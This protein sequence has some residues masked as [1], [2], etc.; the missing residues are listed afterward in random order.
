[1]S[2]GGFYRKA[3]LFTVLSFVMLAGLYAGLRA[4]GDRVEMIALLFIL[5]AVMTLPH[6]LIVERLYQE[7]EQRRNAPA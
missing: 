2:F 5:I 7:R 4:F 1:M 6:M 3:A